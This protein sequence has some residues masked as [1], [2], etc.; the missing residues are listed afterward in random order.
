MRALVCLLCDC[1]IFEKLR[2]TFVSSSTT[3]GGAAA[4]G[5]GHG[6]GPGGGAA[7][8]RGPG[9]RHPARARTRRQ[10]H[11][12]LHHVLHREERT[13]GH[14]QVMTGINIM[15]VNLSYCGCMC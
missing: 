10:R 8:C 5:P 14:I 3:G 15:I 12:G 1:E 7:V 4:G 2:L 13:S 6:P 9:V 11:R